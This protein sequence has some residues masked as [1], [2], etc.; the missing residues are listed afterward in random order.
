M[1]ELYIATLIILSLAVTAAVLSYL[2]R[3]SIALVEILMGIAGGFIIHAWFPIYE[4]SI[5][6]AWFTVLASIGALMLTFLAGSELDISVIKKEWKTSGLVGF[7]SYLAPFLGCTAA[8]Y[9]GFGW[10]AQASWLTGL[11]LSTTSVAVVYSTLLEL[12]MNENNYGKSLLTACFVTDFCTVLSLGFIFSPFSLKT[13]LFFILTILVCIFLP[14]LCRKTFKIFANKPS[15]FEIKF[16]L[17]FLVGLGLAAVWAGYEPVLPAF[18]V[19]IALSGTVGKDHVLI[20]HL[21]AITFGLLTPFYFIRAGFLVSVPVIISAAVPIL[22]FLTLKI[23]FKGIGVY[24]T[25]NLVSSYKKEVVYTTL[26]MSTGLAFGSIAALFGL[27]HGIID[28][29]KY[30][31]LIAVVVASAIIPT[32]IANAFYLPRDLKPMKPLIDGG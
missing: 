32:L 19:G 18:F 5:N 31:L 12:G 25:V 11:V 4:V 2:L 14:F 22:I 28:Q 17:F 7:A 6:S 3:I 21:Q 27:T 13:I 23:F 1:E 9:Y 24:S 26:L 29:Q 10:S 30:S 20:R 16:I 8:A 15:A